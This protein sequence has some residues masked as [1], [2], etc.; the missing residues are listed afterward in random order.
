[1]LPPPPGE[2]PSLSLE[3]KEARLRARVRGLGRG[4]VAFSGGVD[5]ALLAKV[6]AEELGDRALAAT[7]ASPA[8]PPEE[9]AA[10]R[11]LAAAIGIAHVVVATRELEDP[12]YAANP[13]D[14]C[15][16][17]KT[18]LMSVLRPLAQEKGL[19]AVL[20]GVNADDL[21]DHRPGQEAARA[22]GALSPLAE[23]GLTKAEVRALARKL[24]L[25]VWD[26]PA[27]PC[28][29]SR[30]PYGQPV[31]AGKLGRIGSA[32]AFLRTEGFRDCRVRHHEALASVEVPLE[33]LHRLLEPGMRER[34]EARLKAL[35][36]L[37]VTV[38]LGGLKSGNLNAALAAR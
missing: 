28:L 25:P 16:F 32:E 29:A 19:T 36:F 8:V 38:D 24:G 6:C 13:A 37:H 2:S 15:A 30:I 14:R 3:G 33:D 21:G 20:L 12:R 5:S 26:K 27:Q 7:G 17:C 34:V 4:L 18:E 22:Q 23:A 10:A 9:V 11:D 31:T 1:M 35:G